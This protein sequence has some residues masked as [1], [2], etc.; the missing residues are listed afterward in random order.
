[1][2]WEL[3]TSAYSVI[4]L[5]RL[6]VLQQPNL[7]CTIC[8]FTAIAEFNTVYSGALVS[9]SFFFFFF[10][11]FLSFFLSFFSTPYCR[12]FQATTDVPRRVMECPYG[13]QET[14]PSAPTV[15]PVPGS[16]EPPVRST[17]VM[18][19]AEDGRGVKLTLTSVYLP[20]LGVG[21]AIPL[22]PSVCFH[23]VDRTQ[24][25]ILFVFSTSYLEMCR[26]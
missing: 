18:S 9:I 23:G 25:Y 1:M 3:Y 22:L 13:S 21:G 6:L 14:F 7:R 16:T 2:S 5:P 19:W 15:T 12:H 20:R 4:T 10:F 26:L 24:L 17:R 11:F 8:D